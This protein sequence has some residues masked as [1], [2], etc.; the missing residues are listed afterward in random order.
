MND[1]QYGLEK[2]AIAVRS[3]EVIVPASAAAVLDTANEGAMIGT[4]T[5]FISPIKAGFA[6]GTGKTV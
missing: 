6:V 1:T 5:G 2:T 3:I 4:A